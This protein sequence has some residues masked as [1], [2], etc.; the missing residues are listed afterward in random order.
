[1]HIATLVELEDT[2][3]EVVNKVTKCNKKDVKKKLREHHVKKDLMR[4]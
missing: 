3:S 1:M 2:A 4:K